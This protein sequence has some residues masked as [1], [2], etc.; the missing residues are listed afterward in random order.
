PP[1]EALAALGRALASDAAQVALVRF[2]GARVRAASAAPALLRDWMDPA[3]AERED[4]AAG[5]TRAVPDGPQAMLAYL[6]RATAKVLGLGPGQLPDPEA[7]MKDLGLESFMA[8]ELKSALQAE[9]GVELP[10]GHLFDGTSLAALATV[11]VE[12]IPARPD[13]ASA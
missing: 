5:S 4:G 6:R 2:D 1:E 11:L 7:S 9:L 3:P 10:T 8:F 12:Q 13:A